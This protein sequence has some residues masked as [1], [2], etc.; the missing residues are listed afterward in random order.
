MKIKKI[1]KIIYDSPQSV[2]CF[3]EPLNNECLIVGESGNKYVSLQ[4]VVFGFLFGLIASSFAERALKAEWSEKDVDDYISLSAI[5]L[6]RGDDKFLKAA[7][8]IRGKFFKLFSKLE[9]WIESQRAK[10]KKDGYIDTV[11]GGRRHLPRLIY[12]GRDA[13]K[14]LFYNLLNIAVNSPVQG[15]EALEVYR[16][17][18]KIHKSIKEKNLKSYITNNIHDALEGYIHKDEVDQM[19]EILLSSCNDFETYSIPLEIELEVYE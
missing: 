15:F 8:D 16:A 19:K 7:E 12:E 17:M 18:Y 13:N 5:K 11:Y 2:Y 10:A 14:K 6:F 1:S 3:V 9:P 4:S